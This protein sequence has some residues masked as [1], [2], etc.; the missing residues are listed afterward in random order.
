MTVDTRPPWWRATPGDPPPH[1][2]IAFEVLTGDERGADWGMAAAI[3]VA[4]IRRRTG[5]GPTFAEVFDELL[6]QSSPLQPPWPA[7]VS[8]K[9]RHDIMQSFRRHVAIEWKRQG[10]INW[11]VGVPRSLRVGPSFRE[12]SR[13]RQAGRSEGSS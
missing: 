13:S 5:R 2:Y 11:D 6:P 7:H 10:W 8:S 12:R 1:W 9:S 3:H 4:R